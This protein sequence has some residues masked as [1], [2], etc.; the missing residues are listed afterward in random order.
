M[1]AAKLQRP[2]TLTNP[3]QTS[4]RPPP[5]W[6]VYFKKEMYPCRPYR[7]FQMRESEGDGQ[8][9]DGP[10]LTGMETKKMSRVG[11]KKR[12]NERWDQGVSIDAVKRS[13]QLCRGRDD[14]QPCN[15]TV[16]SDRGIERRGFCGLFTEG[17]K[18][19]FKFDTQNCS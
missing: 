15:Y 19:D 5:C 16:I 2:C 12:Q 3:A 14:Q 7:C 17:D 1:A 11:K 9:E 6:D 8:F 4:M 13:S 10:N 18:P